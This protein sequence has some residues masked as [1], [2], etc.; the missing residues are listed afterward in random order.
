MLASFFH[1]LLPS[2]LPLFSYFFVR[3][4]ETLDRCWLL[5]HLRYYCFLCVYCFSSFFSVC[6]LINNHILNLDYRRGQLSE[7]RESSGMDDYNHD[8]LINAIKNVKYM[9]KP[10]MTPLSTYLNIT[11][12]IK[13][14]NCLHKE[15]VKIDLWNL[16]LHLQMLIPIVSMWRKSYKL[17]VNEWLVEIDCDWLGEKLR[18]VNYTFV[19]YKLELERWTQSL[20]SWTWILNKSRNDLRLVSHSIVLWILHFIANKYCW[21]LVFY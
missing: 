12:L 8:W 11:V 5:S 9:L 2:Q 17:H 15:D 4:N 7:C 16:T 18:S 6:V 19:G 14:A 20:P 13:K 21:T 1:F 10:A 3:Y